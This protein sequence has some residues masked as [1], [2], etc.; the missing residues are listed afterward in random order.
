[1]YVK[2]KIKGIV[3]WLIEAIDKFQ[4]R[5]IDTN[6][7]DDNKKIIDSVDVSDKWVYVLSDTGYVKVS[8]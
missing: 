7:N 5:H 3:G 2:Q 1:M 4:A 8:L 6:E